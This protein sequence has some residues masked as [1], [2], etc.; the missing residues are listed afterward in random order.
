MKI[1]CQIRIYFSGQHRQQQLLLFSVTKL[2]L[3]ADLLSVG[4]NLYL[5]LF[6][7]KHFFKLDVESITVKSP[8][9]MI[10]KHI[11]HHSQYL[12]ENISEQDCHDNQCKNSINT[13]NWVFWSDVAV[14]NCS[15]NCHSI[16]HYVIIDLVP[17]KQ[18]NHL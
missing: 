7:Y 18:Y 6:A 8:Q 9:K 10:I 11:Y 15:H 3:S 12:T 14:C 16:I 5:R 2:L 13:L 17:W 1:H 4:S